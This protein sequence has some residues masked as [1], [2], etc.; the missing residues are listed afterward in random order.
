MLNKWGFTLI[1][2]MIAISIIA[3]I[4]A[5]GFTTFSQSQMRARDSRRKSDLRAIS[6]ALELFRQKNGRYPCAGVTTQNEQSL[7]PSEWII[8]KNSGGCAGVNTLL[9][10]TYINSMPK[11][12]LNTSSYYYQY[13]STG[14]DYTP[15]C[16]A[17][18]WYFLSAVLENPNDP[19]MYANA[20]FNICGFNTASSF[21]YCTSSSSCNNFFMMAG[22]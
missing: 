8:D 22:Q 20:P 4:S 16:R 6:V 9:A 19:E 10:P 11:D 12:P 21:P 17:G 7:T 2:L 18:Q 5:V 1:E 14:A 15:S 3:V 13:Q